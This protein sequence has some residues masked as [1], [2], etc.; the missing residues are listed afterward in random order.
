MA[1]ENT[2]RRWNQEFNHKSPDEILRFFLGHFKDKIALSSSLGIE[3]Q[4]LIRMVSKI[5][6]NTRIFTLDTGRLFPETYDLIERT[7]NKYDI[8]IQVF[9]PDAR[10]VEKM[11]YEKGIN[12]FYE[13][14]ENRKLCCAVRK[15]RPLVR[16]IE[17]LD[18]WITGLRKE[19]SETRNNLHVVE[20]DENNG[21]IKINP[22]LHWTEEEVK[23]YID[24]HNIPYN[25][26]Y[27][28]GYASIGCQP[29]TRAIEPGETLRAGR[30]WWENAEAKECGLHQR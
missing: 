14:V 29:C 5:N 20:W 24:A 4:V 18:A 17:G 12:L 11:V 21:L 25:P 16:A 28:K 27:N 23:D 22:L 3:D 13:S 26:L 1:D 15:L 9:F 7:A 19:Q 10:E 30:W 6:K 2:I 8:H